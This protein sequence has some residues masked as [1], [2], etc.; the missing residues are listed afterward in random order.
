MVSGM[1]LVLR[2]EGEEGT[3]LIRSAVA[4]FEATPDFLSDV[5]LLAWAVIGAL[6]VRNRATGAAIIERAL[7]TAREQVAL[8]TLPY[9]LHHVARH[10]ATSEQ[11][12][13]AG[14]NYNE[15][16]RLARET[17]QR[18]D[19][20]AAL[21]G[22]AWLEARQGKDDCVLHAVEARALC[23]ELGT[24][25]YDVW[26]MAALADRELSLGRAAEALDLLLERERALKT[27]G[28][29]DA[30]LSPAPE[31][32]EV[33]LRLGHRNLAVEAAET[34]IQLA[35][36]KSQPWALA[37]AERCR[38]MLAPE[39]TFSDHFAE[40]FELHEATPDTF[41]RARTHLLFGARLRR[42]RQRVRSRHELRVALDLFDQ[43]G[44]V[45]WADQTG[46]ELTATGET[47]RPRNVTT[48]NDL[49]PQELQVAL[50][51]AGGST[52]REA[53]SSLFLS[54]KTVEYHLGHI[55]RKLGIHSRKELAAKMAARD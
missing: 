46:H 41:E 21:A 6:W 55:Y 28:V 3:S 24:G 52:N 8:G 26:V 34:Y 51:L 54:P 5:R 38:A 17:G 45:P 15:A 42:S 40:A 13:A 22:L 25:I 10:Q 50:L 49:T 12:M 33:H 47:S 11:W 9:L 19:L 37:R 48:I 27:L 32:V 16:V 30:D 18:T 35:A 4:T 23:G 29:V 36:T 31:L 2:G 44:A 1:A 14:A 7:A 53:A 43:L 20:A 39:G